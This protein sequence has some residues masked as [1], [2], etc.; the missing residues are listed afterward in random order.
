MKY[1]EIKNILVFKGYKV[2]KV[3]DKIYQVELG[4]ECHILS[5][6]DL[7]KF[8]NNIINQVE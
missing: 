7:I 8:V 5:E 3:R 2:K 1:S 6:E 4:D